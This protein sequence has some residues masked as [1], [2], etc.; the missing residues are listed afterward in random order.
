MLATF[1]RVRSLVSRVS[2]KISLS[3]DQ[4]SLYLISLETHPKSF[5]DYINFVLFVRVKFRSTIKILS[6]NVRLISHGSFVREIVQ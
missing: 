6:L 5:H 3:Y 1:V 4:S 2:E